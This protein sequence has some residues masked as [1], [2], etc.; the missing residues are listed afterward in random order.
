MRAET[1]TNGI[2]V[3]VTDIVGLNFVTW[4]GTGMQTGIRPATAAELAP[5]FVD[6]TPA[7]QLDTVGI[8]RAL[9]DAQATPTLATLQAAILALGGSIT[10]LS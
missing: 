2:V 8:A 4:D 7:A 3:Q 6:T 5:P 1:Y 10:P 9:A